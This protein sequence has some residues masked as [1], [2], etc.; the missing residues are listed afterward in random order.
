VDAFGQVVSEVLWLE[1]YWVRI[2]VKV[3]LTKKEK[4]A[5]YRLQN[6]CSGHFERDC[7]EHV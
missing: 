1:G 5:I 4:R 3:E 2:C 6:Y 7:S